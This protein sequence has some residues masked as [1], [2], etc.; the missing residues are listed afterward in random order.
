LK[1]SAWLSSAPPKSNVFIIEPSNVAAFVFVAQMEYQRSDRVGDR[2]L[3]ETAELLRREIHDPRLQCLNLTGVRMSK[4]LRHA[5]VFFS[6][7][8]GSGDRGQ[9]LAG[10]KSASGFIRSRLAKKLN[11]RFVPSIDFLYDD[12]EDEARRIDALLDK[13]RE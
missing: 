1:P 10:L 6:L 12:S 5:K 4:D 2:L 8:G 3:E 9:A 13:V 11:L 7:L